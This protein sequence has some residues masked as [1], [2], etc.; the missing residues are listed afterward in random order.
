MAVQT[1]R[2]AQRRKAQAAGKKVVA[3]KKDIP[4]PKSGKASRQIAWQQLYD[5]VVKHASFKVW[6]VEHE[7]TREKFA[8]QRHRFAELKAI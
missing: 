1:P 2:L 5:S 3:P 8:S 6:L 4:K 7:T